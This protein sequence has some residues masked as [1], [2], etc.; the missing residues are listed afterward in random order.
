MPDRALS[1]IVKSAES[2][3][4]AWLFEEPLAQSRDPHFFDWWK[5]RFDIEAGASSISEA[6]NFRSYSCNLG[7]M[8]GLTNEIALR[9]MFR[10]VQ[11][12]GSASTA[13][14]GQTPF[15]QG[16]QSARSELMLGVVVPLLAG[17]SFTR[18]SP[19]LGDLNHVLSFVTG[20]HYSFY[21]T[22][23]HPLGGPR[24]EPLPG[25]LPITYHYAGELGMQL[26]ISLPRSLS[27]FIEFEYLLPL[28]NRNP[29]LPSWNTLG[30]GL[31]WSF[32]E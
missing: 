30:G 25:Q 31:A 16:A 29:D 18:L 14:V 9:A 19:W 28:A 21:P 23:A 8:Y 32:G 20:A 4:D 10:Q 12:S 7:V 1:A 26:K 15:A 3:G 13:V 17:R 27:L 11:V 22:L 5:S 2:S 6:N 24:P